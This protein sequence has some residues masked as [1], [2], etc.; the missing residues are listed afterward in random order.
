MAIFW[1]W[2]KEPVRFTCTLNYY[3]LDAFFSESLYCIMLCKLL[4]MWWFKQFVTSAPNGTKISNSS[5]EKC[6][7]CYII[8][9]FVTDEWFWMTVKSGKLTKLSSAKSYKVHTCSKQKITIF[10]KIVFGISNNFTD[11][12]F[13][14]YYILFT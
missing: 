7:S 8:S 5:G 6:F 13:F 4:G 9:A 12:N 3:W 1:I 10:K 11:W 14:C 2:G